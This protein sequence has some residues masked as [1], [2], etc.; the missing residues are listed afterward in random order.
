MSW[1]CP[2]KLIFLEDVFCIF[3]V[4]PLGSKPLPSMERGKKS[5][6]FIPRLIYFLEFVA[7]ILVGA[8]VAWI[9]FFLPV[10][11]DLLVC[12]AVITRW[13]FQDY[14][15]CPG[16]ALPSRSFW[17]MCFAFLSW[18]H[19]APNL[20]KQF[21]CAWPQKVEP[22]VHS[23][24][25]FDPLM[26]ALPLRRRGASCQLCTCEVNRFRNVFSF[27]KWR[28]FQ[29]PAVR[30]QGQSSI[31][32][33]SNGGFGKRPFFPHFFWLETSHWEI[34]DPE[35]LLMIPRNPVI[36]SDDD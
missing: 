15:A 10:F 6:Y 4:S 26:S 23:A 21:Q 34:S 3:V 17:K 14:K 27:F 1:W 18:V 8:W 28:D 11:M 31:F 29:V 19:S 22:S 24:V 36:F 7:V 13:I 5:K 12:D 33:F 20:Y 30:F 9:H 2:A 25:A 35:I 16:D 32:L